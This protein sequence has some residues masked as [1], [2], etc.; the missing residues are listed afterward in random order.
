M[1]KSFFRTSVLALAVTFGLSSCEGLDDLV[2]L[3]LSPSIPIE[4]VLEFNDPSQGDSILMHQG[5][6]HVVDFSSETMPSD[7][8][9]NLDKM[10]MFKLKNVH[11]KFD[12]R[13]LLSATRYFLRGQ[14]V[15]FEVP[16][17]LSN[18]PS[19]QSSP[20]PIDFA[21]SLTEITTIPLRSTDW[22]INTEWTDL[23]NEGTF[24]LPFDPDFEEMIAN[25]LMSEKK[26][27]VAMLY[28]F[29]GNGP[30]EVKAT[31]ILDLEIRI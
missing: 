29:I 15:L 20:T 6:Y 28:Q 17:D 23:D 9:D 26:I 25:H 2:G 14:L 12:D 18:V 5:Q 7:I 16:S 4:E 31:V 22:I 27:G 30:L 1:K 21:S 24:T 10:S 11:I 13:V 8:T 19:N 3:K